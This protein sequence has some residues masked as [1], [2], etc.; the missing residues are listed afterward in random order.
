M[1]GRETSTMCF[2]Q[3]DVVTLRRTMKRWYTFICV[4]KIQTWI[5]CFVS[6]QVAEQ[7]TDFSDNQPQPQHHQKHRWDKV[8]QGK[9]S[10]YNPPTFTTS[11]RG[12]AVA[13]TTSSDI[14]TYSLHKIS[15][16]IIG[17][18]TVT[19]SCFQGRARLLEDR[20]AV[21]TGCAPYSSV[22]MGS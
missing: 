21:L 10:S 13:A 18:H 19:A 2:D 22:Y 3:N 4:D 20:P 12:A 9:G 8:F 1:W 5:S 7:W 17:F 11:R 15:G 16:Q 14:S 6:S